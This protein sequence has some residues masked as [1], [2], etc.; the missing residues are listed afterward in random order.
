M[1]PHEQR[2]AQPVPLQPIASPPNLPVP[3]ARPQRR[4]GGPGKL[5]TGPAGVPVRGVVRGGA[6]E[7]VCAPAAAAAAAAML[8]AAKAHRR[9][10][11][12]RDGVVLGKWKREDASVSGDV[13]PTDG[14]AKGANPVCRIG[15]S[16]QPLLQ[17]ARTARRPGWF[18]PSAAAAAAAAAAPECVEMGVRSSCFP[19]Q[20]G[21]YGHGGA[22]A[23]PRRCAWRDSDRRPFVCQLSGKS[24]HARAGACVR[25]RVLDHDYDCK[26]RVEYV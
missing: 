20:P 7:L 16:Q 15:C 12:I 22:R 5:A 8:R 18:A 4:H 11:K 26:V 14:E 10:G 1:T 9:E 23:P 21:P 19:K 2:S 6:A 25:A 17:A 13:P 24:V 3:M